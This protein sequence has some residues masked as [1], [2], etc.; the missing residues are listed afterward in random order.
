MFEPCALFTWTNS[1]TQ[2]FVGY[3]GVPSRLDPNIIPHS[4]QLYFSDKSCNK[5]GETLSSNIIIIIH[6]TEYDYTQVYSTYNI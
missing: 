3:R 1:F 5:R 2:A 6:N 4:I